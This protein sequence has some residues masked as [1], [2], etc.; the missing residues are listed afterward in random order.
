MRGHRKKDWWGEGFP[1]Q[2]RQQLEDDRSQRAWHLYL[3]TL[4][5]PYT[6]RNPSYY[7]VAIN[8][9]ILMLYIPPKKD[10]K[11]FLPILEEI[12]TRSWAAEI[13]QAPGIILAVPSS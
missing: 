9:D 3:H 11:F 2:R 7:H 10:V 1:Q 5:H 8:A 6:E 12:K 4:P 13:T